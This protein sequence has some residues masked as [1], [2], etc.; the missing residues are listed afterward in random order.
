VLTLLWYGLSR[1]F[2]GL[3]GIVGYRS[4]LLSLTGIPAA[5]LHLEGWEVDRNRVLGQ[6]LVFSVEQV[7]VH[8]KA[9]RD[10]S[11]STG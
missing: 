11:R 9:L 3:W 6:V 4:H 10:F 2:H 7:V 1:L 5:G 8:A